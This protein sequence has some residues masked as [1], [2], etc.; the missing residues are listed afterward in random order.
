M[1]KNPGKGKGKQLTN[2][3]IVA[4]DAIGFNWTSQECVTRSFDERINDLEEYKQKH[5]NL[6]VKR[7]E[8]S[9]L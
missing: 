2:E 4:F 1:C 3:R 6:S 5:G 8:D 9:S 7:H